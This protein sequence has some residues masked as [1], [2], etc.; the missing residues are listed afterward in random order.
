MK[1][2][3]PVLVLVLILPGLL[4]AGCSA[5]PQITT[6]EG[7]ERDS[8]VTLAD[9]VADNVF[10]GMN[11]GDYTKFA[12]D[13]DS[14]MAKALN[15]KAFSE[16][17][18]TFDERIGK[19]QSREVTKVERVDMVFVV[20]YSADFEKE[21]DVAVSLSVRDSDPPQ[22]AGLWFDSPKLREK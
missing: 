11:E 5:M 4:L 22:V 16:M 15:E 12:R 17:T 1:R 14:T 19:Y 9:P 3:L 8:A 10:A 2:M 7:A 18:Q 20:H 6:L 13:F 21:K